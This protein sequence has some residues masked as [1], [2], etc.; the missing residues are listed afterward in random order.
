MAA[1]EGKSDEV[2]V[3]IAPHSIRAVPVEDLRELAAWAHGK[4]LPM[5]MHVSEQVAENTA[6]R[7]EYG[8]T[9]VSLLAKEGLLTGNFTAVHATRITEEETQM[10]ADAGAVICA[11]P[12]TERNLGDGILSADSVMRAGIR[13]ALGSDSQAQIDLLEDAQQLVI[14]CGSVI[15]SGPCSSDKPTAAASRLLDCASINGANRWVFTAGEVVDGTYADFFTVDLD[16]PSIAG[17]SR[18]ICYPFLFWIGLVGNS[19]CCSKRQADHSQWETW[20]MKRLSRDT[21]VYRKI[22]G[23]CTGQ[24]S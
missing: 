1:C 2:Q 12:T 9:P 17:N 7:T 23:I 18:K 20:W 8:S 14:I 16:H 3:G 4:N 19:R 5:H 24:R 6:C 15:R 11:C 13:V 21:R 22:W 10:M